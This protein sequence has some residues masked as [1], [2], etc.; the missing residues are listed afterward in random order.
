MRDS[1]YSP[2]LDEALFLLDHIVDWRGLFAR[3]EFSHGDAELARSALTEGARFA[4]IILAPLNAIGDEFG[5]RLEQGRVRLAPEFVSAYRDFIAAGWPGLDMPE[6]MGGQDLPLSVQVA[7][8]EMINGACAAFGMVVVTLRAGGRLLCE[9]AEPQLAELLVPKLVS[10]EWSATICITEAHAGSDVGRLRT[11]AVRRDDG[12]YEL[13]GTK[14]FI[15]YGDHDLTDQIIHLILARTPDAP[16]GTAGISLFAVPARRLEDGASNGV[17]VS[18][19][20]KKMGLKASPTCVL[21]LDRAL[22]WRIGPEFQGLKCMFTMVNL[23]RLEVAVQGVALAHAATAKAL[24]YAAERP[25]GGPADQAPV[26]IGQHADVRRMLLIMQARTGAL[27]AMVF[28]AARQLDLARAAETEPARESAR[29]LAE[30]LLPVCKTCAAEG[31]FEIASLAVQVFGGHGYIADAGVEQYVRDSRIMAIY[32]GTSGIQ[33]LD[34]LTRKVLKDDG[35]RFR[36][37]TA[38]V[39][40]DL[41]RCD[42]QPECRDLQAP[43]RDVL[44]R[45][46]GCTSWLQERATVAS[47][48]VEAAATDY[49]QLVGLTAGAW[50]WL[51][52]AAAAGSDTAPDRQRRHLARFF[53]QWLLP[54]AV[55]HETRIRQGCSLIDNET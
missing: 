24:K 37:F 26:H 31:A 39:R 55:V 25:Q 4:E 22:G 15:S 19:L 44:Q 32:E 14:I 16:A 5:A 43:V 48:D 9:H 27:R 11:R 29:M 1:S 40:R 10:G 54:Q 38:A 30:F 50:M 23:M 13:T 7:L 47:R 46:E 42:G 53:M 2:P 20:E 21:D 36:L 17:S 3:P 12:R 51:R 18:R 28:E 34:L 52:M 6:L 41:Q 35:A 8:A 49:L 33:S 45:L